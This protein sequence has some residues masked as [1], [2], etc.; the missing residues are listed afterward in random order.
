MDSQYKNKI[1]YLDMF[2]MFFQMY[3]VHTATDNNGEP[4]GGFIGCVNCIQKLTEKFRPQK[5]I[6]V[7]DGP[8]A[9]A[10]RRSLFKNYKGKRARKRRFSTIDFGEG[11][12]EL[13]DNEQIQLKMLFE[14]L[15]LLPI[16]VLIIPYFEADDVIAY[17][18]KKN[19]EFTSIVS[20][21]DKDYLQLVDNNTFVWA[22]QKK[23]LFTKTVVKEKF[24]IIT[25]NFLFMRTIIGDSSDKLGGIKGL[26][27]DTLFKIFP[28]I[29][30]DPF[31]SFENF[32]ESIEKIEGDSKAIQKLKE[33]KEQAHLMYRLMVLNLTSLNQRAIEMLQ[34]QLDQ[35]QNKAFSKISLKMHCIKIKIESHIKD[36]EIWIRPFQF[37]KSDI[38]LTA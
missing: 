21:N 6:A 34:A 10:R 32:W 17:L 14:F 24:E 22:N 3:T 23:L 7:F 1:L 37:L 27:K 2:N 16:Q 13:V 26:G 33:G 31:I 29:Q 28:A 9:G 35:Q 25:E 18:I 19:T 11:D 36:Y 8:E 30:T 38:K 20:S 12:K 15:K 5:V 4:I